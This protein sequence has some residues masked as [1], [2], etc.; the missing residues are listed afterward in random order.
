MTPPIEQMQQA[1]TQSKAPTKRDQTVKNAQRMAYP[2]VYGRPDEIAN[3]AASRVAPEDPALKQLFGVTRADMYEAS[4]GRQGMPHLGMLP[5]AAANPRG[6]ESAEGV[7]NKR[8]EQRL[9]DVM[10]EAGKHQGLV[11]GMDPWYY[12]DPMFE[13]MV[14]LLGPQ[15]AAEEYK[16]MNALSGMASSASEVNTEI[17]RGSLAY[18]LQKQGRFNEFVQHGGKRDPNRPADFGEVPGHLAHKTAHA[19]PM[20]NFLNAGNVDMS[21]PKVP[22]YI[23]ASGVP[24]IGFQTRTPVGDAHWS[25]AVGLADTRNTKMMKGKE[26]VPGQSVTTPEMSAL[27]PWW[28]EKIAKQLGLESVPAQARAWGAF[29]PQTGVTT[30]IGSPKLELIAKQIM[31]TAKRLGISPEKARDLVLTGKER[32]GMADGGEVGHYAEGGEVEP[33]QDE[34]L[35]HIMLHKADGES[36]DNDASEATYLAP[37]KESILNRFDANIMGGSGNGMSQAFGGVGYTQPLDEKTLMR[38]ALGGHF[39]QGNNFN[40]MGLDQAS[41]GVNHRLSPDAMLNALL[42]SKAGFN[43]SKNVNNLGINYTRRFADGGAINIKDVG[44]NEA[45]DLPVKAYVSPNG[46]SGTGLPIGGVDFQPLTP[47]NQML[48]MQPGQ[49]PGQPPMP[50]QPPQGGMPP[51]GAPGAPPR[52]GAPQSNILSLTRP[53]QAMQALRPNPQAMPRMSEGGSMDLTYRGGDQQT[54][55]PTAAQKLQQMRQELDKYYESENFSPQ[56]NLMGM[57]NNDVYG[58]LGFNGRAT[59]TQPLSKDANLAAYIEGGG[60]KP[61]D[62]NY[63][64]A[65]NNVGVA[66]NGRFAQGGSTHDIRLTE[67]KL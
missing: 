3:L 44:V 9:L 15:K 50:G 54:N 51:P 26:V 8:N 67:R 42:S 59:L 7:M 47:G 5:G 56:L 30:P 39:M 13:H 60:Y 10:A 38:I 24:A 64:G 14:R 12:M 49:Q 18:W 63:K 53:G 41:V 22:M 29:S 28:A 27:G 21:S 66:Y 23:E 65:V 46:Q 4:K 2:G 52:P 33:S 1:L 48:P 35:A 11:H 16:K 20:Q 19:V 36:V 40:N 43:G 32:M 34:M 58:G 31:L 62:N 45:P 6:S 61:K 55:E 37:S 57:G 17:P 25:R